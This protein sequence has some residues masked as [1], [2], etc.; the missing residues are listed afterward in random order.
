M[1]NKNKN[2]STELAFAPSTFGQKK[3]VVPTTPERKA[4]LIKLHKDMAAAKKSLLGKTEF[5]VGAVEDGFTTT[6][7]ADTL[8]MKKSTVYGI[9]WNKTKKVG[10][11]EKA[12]QL[13]ALAAHVSQE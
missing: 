5:I 7:I 11:R 9:W 6:E 12:R 1:S 13:A 3:E 8:S 2:Q 4:Q 10:K